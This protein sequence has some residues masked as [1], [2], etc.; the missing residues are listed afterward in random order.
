MRTD[1]RLCLFANRLFT[2]HAWEENRE[3]LVENGVITQIQPTG[4]SGH[5][6]DAV[7]PILAPAFMDIQV[8]GAGGLLFSAYPQPESLQVLY[9]HCLLGGTTHFQPTVAT[10]SREVV[11]ACIHAVRK[12]RAD[13]GKGC[14][15]L[16]LEGPWINP[17]KKGAHLDAFIHSPDKKEIASLLALGKDVITMITLAPECVEP[18]LV[19]FI[20]EQGII[21]SA[22]HSN[23]SYEE[24]TEAFN[25]GIPAAT[26]LYNA[27]S[28]LQHRAPGITG[29]IFDHAS[30]CASIIPDGYHVDFAAIRI[31]KK[32]MGERLFV[33]TDAV[34]ETATGPYQ[35]YLSGD[36]Y[37]A[38]GV[39]SGSALTMVKAAKLLV[40]RAAILPEEALRMVSLYPAR[41]MRLDNRLGTIAIGRTAH[42]AGLADDL[43]LL[44]VIT[45]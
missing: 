14:I 21:I 8:Y 40:Q 32:I 31:A 43:S 23:A 11:E 3:I 19:R 27:M 41:V 24:A 4:I 2:G 30:V 42:L 13:G 16:H 9:E 20:T 15:G 25:N 36:K 18:E 7:Y 29:A 38:H 10:N 1:T 5:K 12:Y 26:H 37:E 33:I 35:H 39:L 6:P 17:L 44:E 28:P 45:A 34:T 22:G